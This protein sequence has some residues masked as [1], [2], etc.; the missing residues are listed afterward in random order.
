MTVTHQ[1]VMVD[2][3]IAYLITTPDG[4]YVDGTVG[5]GGHSVAICKGISPQG[6]LICLDVDR[7]SITVAEERLA[8]FGQ[9]VKIIKGNYVDLDKV[10]EEIGVD[11]AHG[12]LLDLGVSSYQ[13]E[14]SGR[15]FSFNKDE[16][17]DMRMDREGGKTARELV[18]TI[19]TARLHELF[20]DYAEERWAKSIARAIAEERRGGPIT[21]SLQLARLVETAIP[22]RHHPR[23]RHP[24]TKT[25]QALRIAVNKELENLTDFLEKAPRLLTKGGR[26]VVISYHSLEDRLV[27]RAF[28][29][30]Q[31]DEVYPH[32]L[33][34]FQGAGPPLIK[35]LTKRALRPGQAE[36]NVNPRSR[37]AIM[38]VAEG[39]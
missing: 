20:R 34:V 7:A 29:G 2:E 22:R 12:I 39:I 33:P 23:K 15:G 30:R 32:K 10:L 27:K 17:L 8:P 9:R 31:Q 6:Q 1:P 38:R 14:S 3:V 16:P 18:N 37:S 36:M 21:S 26:L 4:I 5:T 13:L 24:A 19:S 11:R 35:T 28:R 25:F